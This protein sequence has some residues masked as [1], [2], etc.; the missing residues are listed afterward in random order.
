[1]RAGHE[2][3]EYG[4]KIESEQDTE[5]LTKLAQQKKLRLHEFTQRDELLRLAEPVKNAYAKQIA[6][7]EVLARINAIQ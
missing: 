2:A 4:R 3:G 5:I 7:E 1:M 6:A